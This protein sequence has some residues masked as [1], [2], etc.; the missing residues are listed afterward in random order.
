MTLAYHFYRPF[1]SRTATVI[2]MRPGDNVNGRGLGWE[3]AS[4]SSSS[5]SDVEF[6]CLIKATLGDVVEVEGRMG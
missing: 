6:E 2:R 3:L 1:L 5:W 4:P